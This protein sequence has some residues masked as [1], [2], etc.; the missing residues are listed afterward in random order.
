MDTNTGNDLLERNLRLF[1]Y[2]CTKGIEALDRIEKIKDVK[3]WEV[4]D[5]SDCHYSK[6]VGCNEYEDE[7]APPKCVLDDF[8]TNSEVWLKKIADKKASSV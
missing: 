4:E 2:Y 8:I 5:L 1:I 6:H 7:T 3:E